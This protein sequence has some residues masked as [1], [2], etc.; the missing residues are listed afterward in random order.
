LVFRLLAVAE[1]YTPSIS[2]KLVDPKA[3]P[4]TFTLRRH[5]L[6]KRAPALVFR[7]RVLDEEGKPVPDAMV[8]PRGFRKGDRGQFGGLK[9]FDPLA[10]TNDKGEFQLG[11]PEEGLSLYVQ[12][13]AR[14]KAPR[15]FSGLPAGPKSHDLTLFTGV[16]VTG[17][18]VKDGRPLSGVA[19][20]VAQKNRSAETFLGP[21]QAATDEKGVFSIPNVPQKD[22]LVLYGLMSSL[23]EQG[24]IEA[25]EVQTGE[26]GSELKVT[27]LQEQHGQSLTVTR[28]KPH[29]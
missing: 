3:E 23:R 5:D 26:S 24:A 19:V 25:R 10:V 11:V 6:D 22:V 21:F 7:G 28:E 13:T 14:F 18:V 2:P 29:G 15:K 1:G 9:D 12:V 27:D 8:E 4:M 20:G 16:T 17:R